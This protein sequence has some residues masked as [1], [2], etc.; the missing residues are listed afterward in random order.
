M[1]GPHHMH[2]KG[3]QKLFDLVDLRINLFRVWQKVAWEIALLA[4]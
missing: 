2:V 3:G 1:K 4:N